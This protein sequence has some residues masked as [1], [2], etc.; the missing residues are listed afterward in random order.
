[1]NC[2]DYKWPRGKAGYDALVTQLR[3]EAPRFGQA[4]LWEFLPCAYW[5]VPP[6]PKGRYEGKPTAGPILVVGTTN[7]PS[8]PYRWAKALAT[9][10]PG[11]VLLTRDGDGHTGYIRSG[12]RCIDDAVNTY[13]L[14]GAPPTGGTVC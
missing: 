8:T 13:L 14:D 4:F 10:I 5:P 11:A 6:T 2:T 9:A 7:D 1:M 12:N 3:A